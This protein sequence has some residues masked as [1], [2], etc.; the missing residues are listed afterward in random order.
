MP[1]QPP[2]ELAMLGARYAILIA[3]SVFPKE[4]Q[5]QPLTAPEKDVDGVASVL[6]SP[7]RG[8]FSD[9]SV[10]KNR[11]HHEIASN[12]HRVLR[13]AGK[14]DLVVMY[15]SG[16][17]KLNQSG[18]LY[19][20]ANDTEVDELE[21]S[22]VAVGRI[23]D[24]VEVSQS[25]Q[26]VIILDCCYSGAIAGVFSKSSIDDQLKVEASKGRGMYIMTASTG[27]QTALEKEADRYSVFTKHL[28]A[29]IETGEAD[30]NRDGVITV[31]E[32]YEYLYQR[33][34]DESH[35]EPTR[36][37][38]DTRGHLILA[39]SG[40]QFRKEREKALRILLFDLS[41]EERISDEILT[42]ALTLISRPAESLLPTDEACDA[43]LDELHGAKISPV[44]FL[45]KWVEIRDARSNKDGAKNVEIKSR[46]DS[47]FIKEDQK[48]K[49]IQKEVPHTS[50]SLN[51]QRQANVNH[52]PEPLPPESNYSAEAST[53]ETIPSQQEKRPLVESGG[54]DRRLPIAYL[55]GGIALI[56]VL[57]YV[58]VVNPHP[59]VPPS[60]QTEAAAIS[61]KITDAKPADHEGKAKAQYN[62][63]VK[64]EYGLGVPKDKAKAVELYREAAEQG[65]A[66]AQFSLGLMYQYGDVV[67]KDYAK[68]VKWYR[69]AAEQG[70]AQAQQNLGLMYKYGRGVPEDEA[71]A[72]D[73]YR[74]AA[75]QGDPN[76][77]N[78]L[79]RWHVPTDDATAVES[80]RRTA[81]QGNAQ[82]QY[83][84]GWMY[85]EGKGVPKDDAKAVKWYRKAAEQGYANAQNNL[86]LM[87]QYGK[88][89]PKDDAKALEWYGKAV[90]QGHS[91]AQN[92]L[93]AME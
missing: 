59:V 29:G 25:R 43:L 49:Q 77:Q 42:D 48:P 70:N 28:I 45:L 64:Y 91:D 74:K 18:Q 27:I 8:C 7:E 53:A 33:V 32:L 44:C 35:Q 4:P 80:Y 62:L 15:Y 2:K 89:V 92:N 78:A 9:V 57:I 60:A 75:K 61:E 30:T 63:G 88:G 24:F 81:Q 37:N 39:N 31:E 73:W 10:L 86:G 14:D 23:R 12:I 41:R 82:A 46:A 65:N 55:I 20:A 50:S 54:N 26:I 47:Q 90:E 83:N 76:A 36:W 13:R 38:V 72:M 93:D 79:R 67:P 58:F 56:F 34:R 51:V 87:Y 6:R 40:R 66:S 69:K 84:L 3:N 85:D 52:V 11:P 5:L 22:A 71:K 21:S 16:H 1:E 68:A 17:G 19:L